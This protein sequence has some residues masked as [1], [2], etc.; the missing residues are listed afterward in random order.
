MFLVG[1][2]ERIVPVGP[3]EPQHCPRCGEVTDFQPRLRYQYGSFD[4]LFGFTYGKRYE[5]ACPQCGH[6]WR[7]DTRTMER[8]L[9]RVP[10]PFRLRFGLLVLAGLMALLAAAWAFRHNG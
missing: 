8:S 1:R 6:G 10:I 5:L 7:L 2:G 9:G 3:P 4:M